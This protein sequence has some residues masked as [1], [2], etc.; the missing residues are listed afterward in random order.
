[1]FN[2]VN[3]TRSTKIAWTNI[4]DTSGLRKRLPSA[5]QDG[6][7][8]FVDATDISREFWE[9]SLNHPGEEDL[10]QQINNLP[11]K[12]ISDLWINGGLEYT[13]D[14]VVYGGNYR[15]WSTNDTR[16]EFAGTRRVL[17]K[18]VD[19]TETAASSSATSQSSCGSFGKEN[20]D[21]DQLFPVD[22]SALSL[23]HD[24]R[25]EEGSQLI[26]NEVAIAVRDVQDSSQALTPEA[27][28]SHLA[29]DKQKAGPDRTTTI[30][31]RSTRRATPYS[32]SVLTKVKRKKPGEHEPDFIP[33]CDSTRDRLCEWATDNMSNS[34]TNMTARS[35]PGV[36]DLL[37]LAHSQVME[38]LL[39]KIQNHETYPRLFDG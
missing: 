21:P 6:H 28:L 20:D 19:S 18:F 26:T 4:I 29:K 15:N 32:D 38:E 37:L 10:V 2:S 23:E 9:E 13:L 22:P 24:T 12:P 33:V 16:S 8:E 27:S 31:Q 3:K 39:R 14:Q 5:P 35:I 7:Q 36:A 11:L 30:N 25:F 1:M 34:S 17:D